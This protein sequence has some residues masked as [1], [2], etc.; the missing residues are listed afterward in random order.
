MDLLRAT[1]RGVL[2]EA[3]TIVLYSQNRSDLALAL[4]W[5]QNNGKLRSAGEIEQ[6]D[7]KTYLV[8]LRAKGSPDDA[9]KL[10]NDR[11]GSFVK[12]KK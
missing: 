4:Q 12:V 11:F 1:V 5:V 10:V 3:R 8:R 7:D 6:L 9:I 2:Q